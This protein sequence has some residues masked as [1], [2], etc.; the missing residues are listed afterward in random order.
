M[1][2]NHINIGFSRELK[3]FQENIQHH[4]IKSKIHNPI[5]LTNRILQKI[6]E[7]GIGAY[8]LACIG[9]KKNDS[10]FIPTLNLSVNCGIAI[11]N[12]GLGTIKIYLIQWIKNYWQFLIH[13]LIC[14][15]AIFSPQANKC[16]DSACL[17]YGL[18]EEVLFSKKSDADFIV[19][20]RS[21]E[22]T[23]LRISNRLLIKFKKYISTKPASFYYVRHPLLSLLAN[24]K[25]GF[26][27]RVELAVDHLK[28]FFSY[29]YSSINLPLLTLVARDY[30]YTAVAVKLN[31]EKLISD[32]VLT[33]S[34]YANQPLWM[35]LCHNAKIHMIWYA[36]NFRSITY[37]DDCLESSIPNL[38]WI[39]V[40]KH[41]VWTQSFA[42]FLEALNPSSES[43]A[44]GPIL[45][46]LPLKNNE[47]KKNEIIICVFD[48]SPFSDEVA[49]AYGQISNYNN[50]N[51]LTRFIND[52]LELKNQI[53]NHF[54]LPV[55]IK[56]KTKRGYSSAY[57]KSYFEYLSKLNLLEKLELIDFNENIYSLILSSDLI[58]SY[59]FTSTNYVSDFL[60]VPSIYYDPTG[61]IVNHNFSD[62]PSLISFADSKENLLAISIES[63]LKKY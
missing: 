13:W 45:W 53:K 18:T 34:D 38:P 47:C 21:S 19:F 28:L 54:N 50:T 33:C 59:P 6:T 36:Q 62:E 41:W 60:R 20:C 15:P 23:P 37:K 48:I 4:I 61:T 3:L 16:N 30:A 11:L 12:F 52:I 26:F 31:Q 24:S 2:N 27:K 9:E 40:D 51:N 8:V 35:N 25:F 49:L 43:S 44:I 63:L 29:T 57:D 32:I 5:I 55:T 17:I 58:I 1:N 10:S 46:R 7:I 14:W 42:K 22:I 39:R 56:L